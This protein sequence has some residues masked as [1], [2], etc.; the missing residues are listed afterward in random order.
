MKVFFRKYLKDII[1]ILLI[2]LTLSLTITLFVTKEESNRGQ[3]REAYS[4]STCAVGGSTTT[5]FIVS[6]DEWENMKNLGYDDE[7]NF[8]HGPKQIFVKIEGNTYYARYVGWN[9]Y[10][11]ELDG[12]IRYL[13]SVV[14]K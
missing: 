4:Y 12:D 3:W 8:I 1:Y 9:G 13:C 5:H 2:V 14:W 10:T 6:E 7:Y 11:R